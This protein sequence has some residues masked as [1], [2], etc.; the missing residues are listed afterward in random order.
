MLRILL[1]FYGTLFLCSSWLDPSIR[2][3]GINHLHFLPS[4][5]SYFV[6]AGFL[7]LLLLP[8]RILQRVAETIDQKLWPRSASR[9]W[10]VAFFAGLGALVLFWLFRSDTLLLGDGQILVTDAGGLGRS[11][12][13]SDIMGMAL[14]TRTPLS[15]LIYFFAAQIGRFQLGLD[16]TTTF[17]LISCFA[18]GVY[19][20]I[21]LWFLG[22][23]TASAGARVAGLGLLLFP[24]VIMLSFG[25]VEYYPLFFLSTFF[26]AVLTLRSI[27]QSRS[28]FLPGIALLLSLL[29]HAAGSVLIPSFIFLLLVRYGGESLRK[30]T[31]PKGVLAG[32]W[33][34]LL[35]ILAWWFLS[36]AYELRGNFLPLISLDVRNTY[37]LFSYEHLLD[38]ANM[39]LLLCGAGLLFGA[40]LLIRRGALS[41]LRSPS[42]L[43]LM[44]MTVF[45]QLFVFAANTDIGFGRDWDVMVSMGAGVLLL[46]FIL[47]REGDEK[48]R[49]TGSDALRF[50]GAM[51]L[52]VLPWIAVNA[53]GESTARRFESLL[54][55]DK[56]FVG[57][58]RTAY[59]YEVLAIHWRDRGNAR[60]EQTFFGKAIEA[61]DNIRFY[62]NAVI[63]LNGYEGQPD[64]EFLTRIARRFHRQVL[65]TDADTSSDQFQDHLSMYYVALRMMRENGLCA[66]A[67][68]MYREAVEAKLPENGYAVLGIAHCTAEMGERGKAADLYKSLSLTGLDIVA[69]DW[70]TMGDVLL[71]VKEF[72]RA[73][74]AFEQALANGSGSEAVYFGLFRAL[75]ESGEKDKA[76]L[77][78]TAYQRLFPAGRFHGVMRSQLQ[79]H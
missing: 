37:T 75:L 11:S 71:E 46:L 14:Q 2:L 56:Q 44:I 17:Q 15:T 7:L 43:F 9:R 41:I 27:I 31:Q 53:S 6:A 59:G 26:Y 12:G 68:P 36:G 79:G 32:I 30:F 21:L 39:L 13:I 34:L 16:V 47:M 58:Y 54:E 25:Y 22:W 8:D 50:S 3:W 18:G 73:V 5:F 19:V 60:R 57:D 74:S 28:L 49:V 42:F 1:A 55:M 78:G 48:E 52:A 70:E 66:E 77:V 40:L 10:M 62:E 63:S 69:K 45:Q 61:S 51:L 24:G 23:G 64:P 29:L 76:L 72:P 65:T 20:V 4:G 35:L 33:A 67:L 38:Y